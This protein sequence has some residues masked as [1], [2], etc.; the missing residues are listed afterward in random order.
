MWPVVEREGAAGLR[1]EAYGF[2]ALFWFIFGPP[3]N[4]SKKQPGSKDEVYSIKF[5]QGRINQNIL[6]KHALGI[7]YPGVPASP[8]RGRY[9][10]LTTA[11]QARMN[12]NKRAG[13][14][15]SGRFQYRRTLKIVGIGVVGEKA[16]FSLDGINDRLALFRLQGRT[17]VAA[18]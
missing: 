7:P 17:A 14:P 8:G 3:W 15:D 2:F 9:L 1:G 13:L 6:P 10:Q 4:G 16:A 5:G 12:G 11:H 18:A